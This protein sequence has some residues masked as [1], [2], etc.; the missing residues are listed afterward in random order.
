M[1]IGLGRLRPLEEQDLDRILLWRNSERIRQSMLSDHLISRDEHRDWFKNINWNRNIYLIFEFKHNPAGM[2][3]FNNIDRNNKNCWWGFYLGKSNLPRGT[4]LLMAY[5]GLQ[6]VF[7]EVGLKKICSEALS[8]NP[9]SIYFH[10]KLG[11]AEEGRLI[12]QMK[13]RENYIDVVI[14]ALFKEKWETTRNNI[15]EFIQQY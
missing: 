13:K 6:Y 9:I 4:G 5:L 11:F 1:E 12:Q 15:V 14:L 10:K 2:V 7:I 3:Y 8:S